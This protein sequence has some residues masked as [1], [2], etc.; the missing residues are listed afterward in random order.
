VS[1]PDDPIDIVPLGNGR[2]QVA[3]GARR[4]VA[5]AVAG[6]DTWVFINGRTFVIADTADGSPRRARI[7]EQGALTAPMPATVLK[8]NAA[9]G[10]AIKRNDVV[11]VLEAMKMELPIRSPRDGVVKGIRCEAGELVQ[12]GTT[13]LELEDEKMSS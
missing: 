2:F 5:Y 3:Q 4:T 7:D 13:L 8:I 12:P 6:H 9:V 1:D 10:Q 11:I